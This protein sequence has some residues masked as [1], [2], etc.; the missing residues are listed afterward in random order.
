MSEPLTLP[1]RAGRAAIW[2]VLALG[3]LAVLTFATGILIARTLSK[4]EYAA[5]GLF[6]IALLPG[7]LAVI[8]LGLS[9]SVPK[10]AAAASREGGRQ[11]LLRLLALM[12]GIKLAL[13]AVVGTFVLLAGD[14]VARFLGIPEGVPQGFLAAVIGIA[15]LELLAEVS[16]QGLAT[17]FA[18]G[19]VSAIRVVESVSLSG[20][21]IAFILLGKGVEGILWA[22]ATA[23]F[24]KLILSASGLAVHIRSLP[25]G[26]VPQPLTPVLP[27]LARHAATF[28]AAKWS[29]YLAG[30]FAALLLG[31][32]FGGAVVADYSLATDLSARILELAIA[33]VNSLL[34]PIFAHLL[35]APDRGP[36]RRAFSVLIKV[37]AIVLLPA[38]AGLVV[39][40]PLLFRVLY[41]ERYADAAAYFQV[42]YGLVS[43]DIVFYSVASSAMITAERYGAF[44]LSRVPILLAAVAA[45]V[46]VPVIGP[47]ATVA[48]LAG[49]RVVAVALLVR[50]AR[51]LLDASVP[52]G[53]VLRQAAIA[54]VFAAILW[55]AIRPLP[56]SPWVLAAAI[57]VYA[58]VVLGALKATGGIGAE[59][60][61][62]LA[63]MRLPFKRVLLWLF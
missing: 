29:G 24:L 57:P 11:G 56:S 21:L 44:L 37:Y 2:N 26:L 25:A 16:Q 40:A 9:A 41:T 60:R 7:L 14:P 38:A 3:T 17:L 30:P 13:L 59:D 5:Y 39:L 20:L 42:L 50:S 1:E 52:A 51:R 22:F 15:C 12:A 48:V 62:A 58:V 43:L 28:Y 31:R 34:L 61:A 49:S 33:P 6:S 4:A 47:L 45:I 35:L 53:F 54:A 27:R 23:S 36:V 63:E 18:Q 19:T 46:L 10:F 8:D 55:A 32:S